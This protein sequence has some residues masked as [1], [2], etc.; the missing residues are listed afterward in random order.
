MALKNSADAPLNLISHFTDHMPLASSDR[1]RNRLLI[2]SVNS[3]TL[4]EHSRFIKKV[5]K[6]EKRERKKSSILPPFGKKL[7]GGENTKVETESNSRTDRGCAVHS[8]NEHL[9]LV[10]KKEENRKKKSSIA[11]FFEKIQPHGNE[12]VV[13][14]DLEETPERCITVTNV[15]I[16]ALERNAGVNYREHL[17]LERENDTRLFYAHIMTYFLISPKGDE[18]DELYLDINIE[19]IRKNMNPLKDIRA[20]HYI[21]YSVINLT[22]DYNDGFLL[23]N[24]EPIRSYDWYTNPTKR[25]KT[26]SKIAPEINERKTQNKDKARSPSRVHAPTEPDKESR[27]LAISQKY[28]QRYSTGAKRN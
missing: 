14:E 18:Y 3:K 22:D 19:P 25:R 21:M 1:A 12:F 26:S 28:H 7:S 20:T 13:A 17:L 15:G 2:E 23:I 4:K 9:K 24:I 8:E 11:T 10:R 16:E 27:K 5:H 6:E